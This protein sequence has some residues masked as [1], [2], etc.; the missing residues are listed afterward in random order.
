MPNIDNNEILDLE[1]LMNFFLTKTAHTLHTTF[2]P[3]F[4]ALTIKI[5]SYVYQLSH[6]VGSLFYRT[7]GAV[8]DEFSI[9]GNLWVFRGCNT[10]PLPYKVFNHYPADARWFYN[11]NVNT[12]Y[13][14]LS[15]DAQ[16]SSYVQLNTV[17]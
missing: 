16:I 9:N 7:F 12:L 8:I 11:K 17:K 10:Q 1:T 3:Q 15:P 4:T 6:T 5:L 13:E 14:A 2:G